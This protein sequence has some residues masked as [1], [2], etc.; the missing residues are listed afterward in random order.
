MDTLDLEGRGGCHLLEGP[1]PLI[2]QKWEM[3]LRLLKLKK[4]SL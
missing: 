2:S 1:P 4:K 3:F